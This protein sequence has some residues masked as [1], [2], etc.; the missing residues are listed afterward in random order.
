MA[1]DSGNGI[2]SELALRIPQD[3]RGG[4]CGKGIRAL[5]GA[6]RMKCA[7]A[8]GMVLVV[9]VACGTDPPDTPCR[10][11][12]DFVVDISSVTG[13]LTWN[14]LVTATYGGGSIETYSPLDS[15]VPVVLFCTPQTENVVGPDGAGG[16]DGSG[17]GG[18]SWTSEPTSGAAGAGTGAG[19]ATHTVLRSIQCQLWTGGPA[20]LRVES[21][22]WDEKLELERDPELCTPQESL[23]LG[24]VPPKD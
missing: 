18:A 5:C 6:G 4:G 8:V 21:G 16:D 22:R 2:D 17:A 10:G 15:S 23:V 20:T 1:P 19:G 12:P 24:Y 11:V 3:S 13:R 7:S 14:T 9:A